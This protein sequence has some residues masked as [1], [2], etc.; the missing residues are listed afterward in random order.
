M[1][2]LLARREKLRHEAAVAACGILRVVR[3]WKG[4]AGGVSQSPYC[5]LGSIFVASSISAALMVLKRE[6]TNVDILVSQTSFDTE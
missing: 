1:G 4:R 2:R 6:V 3:P 5:W